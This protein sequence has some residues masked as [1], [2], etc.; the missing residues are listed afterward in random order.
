MSMNTYD[1]VLLVTGQ[2][3]SRYNNRKRVVC[4]TREFAPRPDTADS[5]QRGR[6]A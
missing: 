4:I 3:V 6:I 2:W 1:W 5:G